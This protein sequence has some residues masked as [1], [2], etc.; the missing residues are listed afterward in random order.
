MEQTFYLRSYFVYGGLQMKLKEWLDGN[1][2]TIVQFAK[3]INYTPG[4]ISQ[5]IHGHNK[6]GKKFMNIVSQATKC[7]VTW[8]DWEE[9]TL[10]KKNSQE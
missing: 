7:E 8:Y 10:Q 3:L 5:C 6:P 2:Y 1:R 4:F 9:I